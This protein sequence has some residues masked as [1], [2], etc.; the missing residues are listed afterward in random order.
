MHVAAHERVCT[1]VQNMFLRNLRVHAYDA[2]T[3]ADIHNEQRGFVSAAALALRA[4]T[5]L[6]INVHAS[7]A[8]HALQ[9]R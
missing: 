2:A 8:Q 3:A 9:S 7:R 5:C 1:A 6:N 4:Q